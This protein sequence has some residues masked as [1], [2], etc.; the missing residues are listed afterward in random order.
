MDYT[1]LVT[2]FE[3][4]LSHAGYVAGD[5]EYD[6]NYYLASNARWMIML[7]PLKCWMESLV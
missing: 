3:K 1:I 2:A 4:A 6:I 7:V 5:L